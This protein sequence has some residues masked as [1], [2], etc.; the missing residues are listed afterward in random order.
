MK[1]LIAV[2][3]FL[4]SAPVWAGTCTVTEFLRLPVDPTGYPMNIATLPPIASQRVTYT[5]STASAVFDSTSNFIRIQCDATAHFVVGATPTAT[6][7]APRIAA[8]GVE[9]FFLSTR[10]VKIAFYDGVS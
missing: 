9:Y 4:I 2:L 8:G 10:G 1:K 7:A 6:N 3:A 5:T